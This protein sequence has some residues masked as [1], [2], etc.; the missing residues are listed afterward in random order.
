MKYYVVADV[1]GFFTPMHLALEEAGFFSE[2]EEHKL[3]MLGDLFDRGEEAKAMQEFV[4]E[5]M[6]QNRIILICGNHEDLYE[7]LVTVDNGLPYSHHISNG[8]Y[9][10]AMQLTGIDL[11]MARVRP[12]EFAEAAK[13]TPYYETILPAMLDYYETAKYVFVHGWLPCIL[14]LR[15]FSYIADW[16]N[17]D[18]RAWAKARWY[19]GMEAAL[20]CDEE[21]TVVCGHWHASYGHSKYEKKGSEFGADADFSPYYGNRI[22]A[23]DACT[24]HSGRVNV[25]VL[26]GKP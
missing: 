12:Y 17:A 24:A 13:H 3:V 25:L 8:T 23:L 9:D 15:K 19:N 7:E 22:I 4:L 11:G 26:D 18:A 10:T 1:H 2:T 21:K 20:T 5:M 14:G 16:R 6:K